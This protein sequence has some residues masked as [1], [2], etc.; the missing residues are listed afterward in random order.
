MYNLTQKENNSPLRAM[1]MAENASGKLPPAASMVRPM[2]ESGTPK[3]LPREQK[4][5]YCLFSYLL[6]VIAL[7]YSL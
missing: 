2:T 3:V 1:M 4:N 7:T 6:P 5:R